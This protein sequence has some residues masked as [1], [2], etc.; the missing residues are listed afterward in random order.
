VLLPAIY[1]TAGA[2]L[3]LTTAALKWLIV[4][5]YRPRVEPQWSHFVWRSEFITGLFE[6]VAAP[7]LL[8]WL[9]G[10]PLMA[11]ALRLFGSRIGRRVYLES[12]FVTEF[13]LVHIGSDV[14]IEGDVSLQTHLFEDRIMKMSTV[15]IGAGCS[16]GSR[17]V[18][19]Y[20]A[21]LLPEARLGSLSLVM[22]G[23]SLLAGGSW[24]GI[25]AARIS[26]GV[27]PPSTSGSIMIAG[28]R[29]R[30]PGESTASFGRRGRTSGRSRSRLTL[31]SRLK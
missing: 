6:N 7:W 29:I 11:P 15:T 16:I 17:A 26:E 27:L 31:S 1:L 22:K 3:T 24:V 25:P 30:K 4:Q 12:D 10:T 2:C 28:S 8:H 18:V 23:E 14:A 20:D 9:K 5:R 21:E 19:L 13:D